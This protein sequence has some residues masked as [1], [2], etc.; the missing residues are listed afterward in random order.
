[1]AVCTELAGQSTA[2]ALPSCVAD[3]LGP[4]ASVQEAEAF[5]RRLARSHYENF[6]VVSRLLPQH[7]R[8]DFCNVYA[9]C[10]TADDLGDELGDCSASL[11][12][13]AQ[14]RQQ[15]LDCYSGKIRSGLFMALSGTISRHKI[16][17][18]PFLDLI[19]AFEQDQRVSRY[20][21]FEQLLDYCRRSAN[22]VGRLVLYMCGYSDD[23]RQRLSDQ[24]CTA[25]QLANFWQ[26]V[27]RDLGELDRIYIPADSMRQFE[28]TEEQLRQ[29]RCDQHYRDLIRFEVDRAESLFDRGAGL[30]PLLDPA[31]RSQIAL[32]EKGGRAILQAIRNQDYDTLSR[33]PTL[34]FWQK[35]GLLLNVLGA[36][37]VHGSQMG[38]APS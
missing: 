17:V 33:R 22:P 21:T 32:F 7:L 28:V 27:Q 2:R 3:V 23:A 1:M 29:G 5:T 20:A 18:D 12:S 16:P 4:A 9:F 14:L 31:V 34:S 35:T 15:T 6:M 25:L 19:S 26:D 10:R 38:R 13:L 36:K 24:T 30:L 8:Q 37:I 11:S